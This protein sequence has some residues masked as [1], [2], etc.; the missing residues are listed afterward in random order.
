MNTKNIKI[1]KF[2]IIIILILILLSSCIAPKVS[3]K[4]YR[5]IVLSDIKLALMAL[6]GIGGY[7]W[8]YYDIEIIEPYERKGQKCILILDGGITWKKTE[9]ASEYY[10]SVAIG[11]IINVTGIEDENGNIYTR[12]DINILRLSQK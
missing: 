1:D 4:Q 6:Q 12:N 9:W 5:V 8:E 3:E 11:D 10:K 2:N 7:A